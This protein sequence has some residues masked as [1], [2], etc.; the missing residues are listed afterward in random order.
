VAAGN[1]RGGAADSAAAAPTLIT[2][3]RGVLQEE[4]VIRGPRAA[5]ACRR[6]IPSKER[7][8]S[9]VP[10]EKASPRAARILGGVGSGG[11]FFCM[12]SLL[13]KIYRISKHT[14]LISAPVALLLS[15]DPAKAI[16][17]IA[18]FD[19][20][21]NLK[22]EVSGSLSELGSS[23]ANVKCGVEGALFSRIICTGIDTLSPAY[24]ISGPADF[25]GSAALFPASFVSG[26]FLAISTF[27]SMLVVDPSYVA[28][29]PFLS[30]ATFNNTNAVAQGFTVPGLVD[31]WTING[32]SESIN[33]FVGPPPAE[34]PG[35]LPL[36]G[37][38]AAFGWS[39]RIRRRITAPVSTPPQA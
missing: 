24:I 2:A 14:A 36:L 33:L 13:N 38:G 26:P 4:P 37:A 35:P 12:M 10:I 8:G 34:V 31:T 16:L 21:P 1:R 23:I 32:T 27:D 9:P 29:Q 3:A 22:V 6:A 11:K 28:G 20:G 18:I 30:S 39:R 17:N 7:Q 5:G 19:D 25:G 15:A